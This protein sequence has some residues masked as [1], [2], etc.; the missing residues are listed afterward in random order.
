MISINKRK[1]TYPQKFTGNDQPTSQQ[2]P[3]VPFPTG[4]MHLRDDPRTPATDITN[5]LSQAKSEAVSF[6]RHFTCLVEVCKPNNN[7]DYALTSKYMIVEDKS[8]NYVLSHLFEN[9]DEADEPAKYVYTTTNMDGEEIDA[10]GSFVSPKYLGVHAGGTVKITMKPKMEPMS[11]IRTRRAVLNEAA[12]KLKVTPPRR[13]LPYTSK[14]MKSM[15]ETTTE[16][17]LQASDTVYKLRKVVLEYHTKC[18]E[19]HHMLANKKHRVN[20]DLWG[21]LDV[22][23]KKVNAILGKVFS[24]CLYPDFEKT[25]ECLLIETRLLEVMADVHRATQLLAG[26]S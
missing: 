21:Q 22:M 14:G 24:F 7:N 10:T 3:F 23:H 9:R 6:F 16:D 13:Y 20:A 17:E 2:Q 11:I 18:F 5:A 25:K 12:A 1:R 8:L 15:L 19:A 26:R 4:T